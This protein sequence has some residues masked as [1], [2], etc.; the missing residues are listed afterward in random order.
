MTITKEFF[1]M[2]YQGSSVD[3]SGLVQEP[4]YPIPVGVQRLWDTGAVMTFFPSEVGLTSQLALAKRTGAKTLFTFGFGA[5]PSYP[6]PAEA[7]KPGSRNRPTFVALSAALDLVTRYP[8]DM[9]ELGNEPALS[10]EYWDGTTQELYDQSTWLFQRLRAK[11]PMSAILSPSLNDLLEPSGFGF[12]EQYCA[13]MRQAAACDGIAFHMYAN[14]V[15]NIN[16]QLAQLDRV[17]T[18]LEHLPRY[19]TEYNGPWEAFD[20]MAAK[21]IKLVVLNGQQPP[22]PYSDQTL[23]VR[24]SDMVTRLTTTGPVTPP[25]PDPRTRGGCLSRIGIHKG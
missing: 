19:C 4:Y 13:L 5:D 20:I 11:V 10:Y 6:P 25:T 21:G 14:S 1:G 23:A 2:M 16:A 15:D 3:T 22:A 24:W 9:Y 18:G 12:A 8:I 7:L 17:T